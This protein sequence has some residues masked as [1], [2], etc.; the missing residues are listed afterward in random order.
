MPKNDKDAKFRWIKPILDGDLTLKTMVKIC[1]FS[2]RSLKYWL[3]HYRHEGFTGLQN[4]STRPKSNANETS[5][6]IKE[7]ILELRADTNLCAQKLHWKLL[8]EGVRVH[9]RTIG[10]I[11]KQQ[12]L[13][14]KYRSRK[15]KPNKTRAWQ[16][17]DMV[18]IDV[19]YV[20]DKIQGKKYYQF[21]AIDCASRWRHMEIYD[22]ATNYSAI[23]FLKQVVKIAD[24]QIKA[25]KTDNGSCF[26]NRYTG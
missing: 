14:R 12:G 26:T 2:E 5:I 24:F 8:R 1:P 23:E 4:K 9:P 10:K 20:P 25:V 17:G 16:R 7:R 6:R 3:A 15:N 18:A 22:S 13:V 19:K 21:T 11:L